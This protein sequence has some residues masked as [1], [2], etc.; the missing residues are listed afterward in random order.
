[1]CYRTLIVRSLV[2]LWLVSMESHA[3]SQW[4]PANLDNS[5]DPSNETLILNN[6]FILPDLVEGVGARY[7]FNAT[8]KY[9]GGNDFEL[10]GSEELDT[11]LEC[12]VEE[13]FTAIPLLN[14]D[15]SIADAN[16]LIGCAAATTRWQADLETG[17]LVSA[18]WAGL[19]GFPNTRS[20]SAFF[21]PFTASP[22]FQPV[23][24]FFSY[25][26]ANSGG[27]VTN[28][29]GPF[30]SFVLRENVL[31]SY[32]YR[33]GGLPSATCANDL[34]DGFGQLELGDN[35]I[36]LVGKLGCDGEIDIVNV[37]ADGERYE[38]QWI[39]RPGN[40]TIGTDGILTRWLSQAISVTLLN[41]VAESFSFNSTANTVVE[42]ACDVEDITS[43][44]D[45][46]SIG[47]VISDQTNL[48][49]C[50]TWTESSF[51]SDNMITTTMRWQSSIPQTSPYVSENRSLVIIATDGVITAVDLSRF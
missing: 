1:M 41:G 32:S 47:D 13:V 45:Q 51:A 46:F 17:L 6:V 2:L 28:S 20:G 4:V 14:L 34:L 35:Y 7:I 44:A 5:Y 30:I 42:E 19:D 48:L 18:L 21:N 39:F 33:A 11:E 22:G 40:Q 49:N 29:T 26:G 16:E 43:A 24:S 36:N 10:V 27:L 38:Y 9:R 25:P 50:G 15:M 37:S 31:Q 8:F 12:T 23:R 3:Q